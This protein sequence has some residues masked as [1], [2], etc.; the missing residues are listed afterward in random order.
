MFNLMK[1]IFLLGVLIALFAGNVN[2]QG[3]YGNT[4]S[5]SVECVKNLSLYKEFYDQRNFNAALSSWR[6]CFLNCPQSSENLFIRGSNII[7]YFIGK[8][9]DSV[10]KERFVDTLMMVYDKRIEYFGHNKTSSEGSVLG[11]KAIDLRK[12]RPDNVT[13][14]YKALKRSV[15]LEKEK[16]IS[17]VLTYYFEYTIRMV[18][19]GL[20]DTAL[21]IDTYSPVISLID[22]NIKSNPADTVYY[23]SAKTAVNNLF[24]PWAKCSDLVSVFTKKINENPEDADLLT[25]VVSLFEKQKC[26]DAPL[27]YEAASQL[28]KLQ[29]SA[30]SAYSLGNMNFNQKKY[31]EAANYFAQAA[32]L[33]EDKENKAKSYLS[34]AE[35][36][37]LLNQF[38]KART[39]ALQS[40]ENNPT[41]GI[42]YIIIGD[43]YASSASSCGS[44]D[45]SSRAA[46]W[47]AVDKYIKARNV[48]NSENVKN[49]ASARISKYSALFPDNE[50]IFFNQ[51]NI[52][53]SYNVG[54]W[55]NETTTIRA[56]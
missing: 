15:E 45:I 38:Q 17:A 1:N 31:Q 43:M 30:T 53:D 23:P 16:S 41:D 3:K 21:I 36:Y 13:D 33:Y 49:E 27:Y 47:A 56:R 14:I 42:P 46:Y 26:T 20:A 8:E 51:K 10:K 52:G 48:S 4:P 34:L 50:T 18:K 25:L 37:R 19:D 29:P 2:A 6:W 7:N 35:T 12:Y 40:A 11:R 9:K 24:A 22:Y 44:D 39:A 32:E 54:C 28:H 55:I 5:D